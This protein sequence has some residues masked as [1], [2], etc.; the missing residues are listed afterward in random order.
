MK[1][2]I[3]E[4]L[5]TLKNMDADDADNFV[6]W[7]QELTGDGSE[8]SVRNLVLSLFDRFLRERVEADIEADIANDNCM[9]N[10]PDHDEDGMDGDHQSALASAGWGDDEDYEHYDEPADW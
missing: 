5:D 8:I 1:I 9:M 3:A 6:V 4:I 10:H 7:L 2:G